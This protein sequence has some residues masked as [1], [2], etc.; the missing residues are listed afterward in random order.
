VRALLSGLEDIHT[1]EPRVSDVKAV[2]G[3]RVLLAV[4]LGLEEWLQGLVENAGNGDLLVVQT[5]KGVSLI[6]EEARGGRPEKGHAHGDENPHVWLDPANAAVMCRN[7]AAALEAVDST[8]GSFYRKRLEAYVKQLETAA[9]RLRASAAALKDKRFLSYHPAWPYLAKGF[10]LSLV[11]VVTED[12]AQEPSAKALAALVSRV[13][14]EKIRVL[15]T[16]P[17]LPSKIPRLLAQE[18]GVRVVTL[19]DLVG[20][21]GT[22]TYLENLEANVRTLVTALSEAA[23]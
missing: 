3:A 23:R 22:R 11:G 6:R 9:S 5:S 7:I 1:Y 17:Q 14:R 18:A 15:V 13:R 21:G 20:Y 10:G 4:G 8:A 2:A 19:S 16:E 12:P